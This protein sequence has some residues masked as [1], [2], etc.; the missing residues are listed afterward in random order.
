MSIKVTFLKGV[1]KE[2]QVFQGWSHVD[3]KSQESQ[4]GKEQWLV[5]HVAV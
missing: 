3:D 4:S 2:D 1:M 5:R